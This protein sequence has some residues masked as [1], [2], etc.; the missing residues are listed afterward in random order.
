MKVSELLIF[1]FL[2]VALGFGLYLLWLNYPFG[3]MSYAP[4]SANASEQASGDVYFNFSTKGIQFYPNMR[5]KESS[6]SYS[7]ESGCKQET[8][9]NVERAF[10]LISEKTV[11]SF[12]SSS[13]NPEIRILCSE[14]PKERLEDEG[15]FIAGEGGPTEIIN[16]SVY[17]IIIGGK[18]ALYRDE[19]CSE[20]KIAVHEILHALGFDHNNNSMSILYP[21]TNCRQEID[22]YIIDKINSLYAVPS[23]SDLVIESVNATRTGKYLNFEIFVANEGLEDAGNA[24]L[25]V[26]SGDS[27]LGS[28]ELGSLLIG[29]KKMLNVENVKVGGGSDVITFIVEQASTEKELSLANNRAEITLVEQR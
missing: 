19:S 13:E 6:I 3:T 9:D 20:P 14:L 17:A 28:F 2:L 5:F 29:T 25:Q 22:Q 21:V 18:I 16:S 1:V 26:Y 23:E 12:Y 8:I 4:F 10:A 7:I 11:L 15:H 27:N 24:T